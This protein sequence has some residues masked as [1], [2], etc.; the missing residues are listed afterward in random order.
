LA[1]GTESEVWE[2]LSPLVSWSTRRV[3]RRHDAYQRAPFH[4]GRKHAMKLESIRQT[5][6]LPGSPLEVYKALMTTKGHTAFTGA[7]ARISPTVGGKFMAWGGYIHGKNLSLVPGKIIYQTWVPS[8]PNWPKGHE[9]RVRYALTP[10]SSGTR[11]TFIHSRVPAEHVGHL[12]SG[13]KKS[14]WD[15]LR[16]YLSSK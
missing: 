8:D 1:H 5:V 2:G 6:E 11:V 7:S 14:Y 4:P 13:W 10:T 15:P 12:S 3:S 9:S 16:K